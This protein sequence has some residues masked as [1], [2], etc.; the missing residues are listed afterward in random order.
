MRQKA[1]IRVKYN[2]NEENK[3]VII[4]FQYPLS[5]FLVMRLVIFKSI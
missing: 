3:T 4:F 2:L 5:M 1:V